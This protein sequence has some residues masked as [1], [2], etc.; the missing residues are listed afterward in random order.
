MLIEWNQDPA[1]HSHLI[2]KL[3]YEPLAEIVDEPAIAERLP[4][5]LERHRRSIEIMRERAKCKDGTIFFDV[6]DYDLEGYNKFIPY[7]LHPDCT[8]SVGLS[9]SSFRTKVS[10][11]RIRGPRPPI[12]RTWRRSANAM[13]AAD[14]PA[15]VRFRFRPTASTKRARRQKR[16]WRSCGRA[17]GRTRGTRRRSSR[18][19]LG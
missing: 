16:L 6:T 15:W 2:P 14:M 9:K 12:W 4:A 7:Y 3:A 1:I 13:A 5:L 8:Y 19:R 10:V 18:K 11:A 17:T